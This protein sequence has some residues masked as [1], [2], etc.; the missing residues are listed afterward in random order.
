MD[1]NERIE[2]ADVMRS[3]GPWECQYRGN[4]C[5][6]WQPFDGN[7]WDHALYRYREAPKPPPAPVLRP[8]EHH[9][10]PVGSVIRRKCN[11]STRMLIVGV[12]YNDSGETGVYLG[13]N[14]AHVSAGQLRDEWTLWDGTPCGVMV[15]PGLA[16]EANH[17]IRT[18]GE[19][20]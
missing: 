16:G 12:K 3:D 10:V 17:A 11:P 19:H 2:A 18:E 4:P 8:W 13:G 14:G 20:T 5:D 9:E 6:L 15:V 1:R 7:R